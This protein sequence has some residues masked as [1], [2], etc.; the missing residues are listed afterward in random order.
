VCRFD[1]QQC[2]YD[3]QIKTKIKKRV[4]PG[5]VRALDN[6]AEIVVGSWVRLHSLNAAE[7]NGKEGRVAD[8][9]ESRGRWGIKFPDGSSLSVLPKSLRYLSDP[10][11]VPHDIVIGNLWAASRLPEL[12][13][14]VPEDSFEG[15]MWAARR[16][17]RN[18]YLR[19]P[20]SERA[21]NEI[22]QHVEHIDPPAR[23]DAHEAAMLVAE[24]Q[25]SFVN[26]WRDTPSTFGEAGYH[27]TAE[28]EASL[29]KEKL[30]LVQFKRCPAQLPEALTS[31]LA[32]KSCRTALEEAGH[33]WRLPDGNLIFVHPWQYRVA[34]Q[35][36][37]PAIRSFSVIFSEGLEYLVEESISNVA[38]GAVAKSRS[39][40]RTEGSA[41]DEAMLDTQDLEER[42]SFAQ[43]I[44]EEPTLVT[45]RTFLDFIPRYLNPASV[46]QSST[47]IHG[48][49]LNP[50]RVQVQSNNDL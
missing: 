22:N 41:S 29:T 36:S 21:M 45:V 7:H 23:I 20:H 18:H 16:A 25:A 4:S 14:D 27:L 8:W 10:A 15:K 47:E 37:W 39:V 28:P 50:R 13:P 6:R 3:L 30:F 9:F 43:G 46:V 2:T 19:S 17:V 12:P 42:G 34:L 26:L 38:R 32:L 49:G 44:V 1:F 5:K 31:G 35:A 11:D 40:L 24:Q 33:Q 48:G